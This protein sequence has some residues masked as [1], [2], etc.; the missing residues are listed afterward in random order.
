MVTLKISG[1]HAAKKILKPVTCGSNPSP[2]FLGAWKVIYYKWQ[3]KIMGP[4]IYFFNGRSPLSRHKQSF[5][6]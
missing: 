2:M 4:I 5:F 1:P 6:I 3:K